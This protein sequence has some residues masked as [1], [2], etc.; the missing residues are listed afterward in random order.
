VLHSFCAETNCA[1]GAYPAAGL[2]MDGAGNLYGTTFHGGASSNAGVV[3]ELSP[4]AVG[5]PCPFPGVP[6]DVDDRNSQFLRIIRDG[7]ERCG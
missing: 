1:D 7:C 4:N 2:I 3:F 5:T 6:T